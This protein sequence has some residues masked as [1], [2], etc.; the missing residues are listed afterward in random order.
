MRALIEG[1]AARGHQVAIGGELFSDAMGPEGSYEGTYIGM[2]DHNVT[3]IARALGGTA[4]ERGMSGP[5][6]RSGVMIPLRQL[7]ADTT[8]GPAAL[9]IQGMS[10]AY[11]DALVVENV[12]AAFP[13]G[14]MTAIVGP[15]GAGKS[16]LLKATLG[17]IP[18]HRRHGAVLRLTPC[19]RC[20]TGWPTCRSGAGVDWIFPPAPS[21]SS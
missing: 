9:A 8:L 17:I 1:A 18:H 2:I 16:S 14:A 4:P 12:D 5:V 13:S 15:N 3:T 10:V 11:G 19:P 20:A 21:T 7:D 6:G